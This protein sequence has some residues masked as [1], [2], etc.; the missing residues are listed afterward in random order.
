MSFLHGILL[1]GAA[2]FLIPLI[3][4]LLNKRRVQTVRWG[5]MKLL[6]EALRQRKRNLKIE[7]LL[8]LLAR[9]SIPIILALCLARPVLSFLRQLT[10]ASQNSLVVLLDNSFSMRAPAPGGGT[11]RDAMRDD[12]RRIMDNL[13]RGTDVS[14]VLGGNPPRLLIDQPTT[15]LDVINDKL[16]TEPS[17]AGPLALHDAMQLATAQLKRAGSAGRE[18][19][20]MSDFRQKDWAPV[21]DGGV[22]PGLDGFKKE[23]PNA[24]LTFYRKQSELRENLAIASVEPSAFVVARG[25]SIALRVRVH[26]FGTRP[27]QDVAL[28]LE[29][30]GARLRTTRISVPAGGE[31]VLSLSHAFETAGD[32]ALAVRLEGDAFPEDN[33]WPLVV[34]VREQVNCLLVTGSERGGPLQGATDFLQIALT[35]HESAAASLKDVIHASL[36]EDRRLSERSFGGQEVIILADVPRL[37]GRSKMMTEM[38]DFVWRGGGLIVFVGPSVDT[39]WYEQEFFRGG[40]GLFPCKFAGAGHVDEGQP[41]AR[42]LSQRFTHPALSYF[43][44]ARGLRL[45]DAAFQHWLRFD[46]LE[47][48]AHTLLSLDRGDPLMVEKPFGRG[49]VIAIASTANANWNNLPLQPV[50]V[51]LMQRL[52]T[53]LATQNAAPQS[54]LAGTPL[55]VN[56]PQYQAGSEFTLTDPLN[57]P[58]AITAKR[59]QQGAFVEYA[60]TSQPGVYELRANRN[61]KAEVRRFAFHLDPAGSDLTPLPTGRTHE[62]AQHANAGY[63]EGFDEYAQ[64]DRTRRHGSEIWQPLLLALLGLMF[65][66]V[67]LQQRISRA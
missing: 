44:D 8:L 48:E 52:V 9:I 46:K 31:T 11:V 30:D 22:L 59:D 32:H 34:P 43:N 45:Q 42:I 61:N 14:V 10:G 47:G 3:I 35:P 38:E 17:L 25:Q 2:A 29:A 64:L 66:E 63:A 37:N 67:F 53:Y 27:F 26:N 21:A 7:Q 13:P 19:M 55:R 5:A 56:L 58:H 60:D 62:I 39:R 1:A 57:Q 41:P 24:L 28:H 6:Q 49:R 16:R 15:V 20:I 33:V 40:K 51:P 23:H 50:F 36:I 65:G 4:H 18:L 12:L 54:S